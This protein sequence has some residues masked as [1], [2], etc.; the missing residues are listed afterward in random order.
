[1]EKTRALLYSEDIAILEWKF[2]TIL[3]L[4]EYFLHLALP[5]T[6]TLYPKV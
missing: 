4:E 3:A 5:I 2:P 1:M 6:I